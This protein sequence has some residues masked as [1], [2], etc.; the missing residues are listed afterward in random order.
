MDKINQ[1]NNVTEEHLKFS[2]GF[3]QNRAACVVQDF[4]DALAK[5]EFYRDMLNGDL[6]HLSPSEQEQRIE[7]ARAC[8]VETFERMAKAEFSSIMVFEPEDGKVNVSASVI[9]GLDEDRADLLRHALLARRDRLVEDAAKVREQEHGIA[10]LAGALGLT[11][12][13]NKDE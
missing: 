6:E 12:D 5:V 11:G 4:A 1:S 2:M 9:Y 8:Y 10:K 13:N 7:Q 3:E